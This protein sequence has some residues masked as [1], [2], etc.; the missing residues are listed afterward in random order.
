MPSTQTKDATEISVGMRVRASRDRL[1][2]EQQD[3]SDKSQVPVP[4]IKDIERGKTKNPRAK[5]LNALA[6]A[7]NVDAGWLR[8]GEKS[9]VKVAP[10]V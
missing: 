10:E 2:W 3:L 1:N 7:L 4:T 9:P 5:T 6:S 8:T